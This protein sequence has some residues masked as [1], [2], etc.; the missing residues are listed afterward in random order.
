MNMRPGLAV[1]L[2]SL[3]GEWLSALSQGSKASP[4]FLRLVAS[5]FAALIRIPSAMTDAGILLCLGICLVV[6]SWVVHKTL[7]RN[8]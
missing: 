4:S 2:I 1:I 8:N 6:I 3:A 5:P 7:S